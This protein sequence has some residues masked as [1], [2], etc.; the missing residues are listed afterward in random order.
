MAEKEKT[1]KRSF[2][3]GVKSEFLKIAWPDRDTMLKQTT[4][5]VFVSLVLGII[6]AIIDFFLQ[7]GVDFITSLSF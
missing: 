3:K 5:V 7:M 6:I 1:I 4:M 2:W